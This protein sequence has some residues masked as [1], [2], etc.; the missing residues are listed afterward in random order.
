MVRIGGI[1]MGF[2]G[3]QGVSGILVEHDECMGH[4]G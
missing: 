1:V 3:V 4:D 2:P